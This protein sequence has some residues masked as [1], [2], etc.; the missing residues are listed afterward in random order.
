MQVNMMREQYEFRVVEEFAS[1]LFHR[2]E[3]TRLG[4]VRVIR[5]D[6]DDPRFEEIG[7]LQKELIFKKDRLFF[8]GW[9]IRRSYSHKGIEE[10]AL[11]HL[12]PTKLFEPAGEE[13]GTFGR[14]T[15]RGRSSSGSRL[16]LRATCATSSASSRR[17]DFG[18]IKN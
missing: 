16:R 9:Q 8:Y 1:K 10:A 12:I 4:F 13:C 5:I 17:P 7:E 14:I 3:G 18:S 15:S 6:R 2:S 11:W